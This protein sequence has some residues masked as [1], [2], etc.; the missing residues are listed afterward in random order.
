MLAVFYEKQAKCCSLQA[1]LSQVQ[2]YG[3]WR[4]KKTSVTGELFLASC[5]Q[6]RGV[7]ML[8]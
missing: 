5:P 4:Q 6:L 8:Q 2:L 7:V 3:S 1:P